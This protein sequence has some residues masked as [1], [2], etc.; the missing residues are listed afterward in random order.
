MATYKAK[1]SHGTLPCEAAYAEH[2]RAAASND[3]LLHIRGDGSYSQCGLYRELRTKRSQMRGGDTAAAKWLERA[4][5][6]LGFE[7]E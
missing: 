1:I 7:W 4:L 6:L 5:N 2:F 3:N